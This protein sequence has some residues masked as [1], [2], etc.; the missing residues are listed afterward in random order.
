MR[1]IAFAIS[2]AEPEQ[3][4]LAFAKIK[5]LRTHIEGLKTACAAQGVELGIDTGN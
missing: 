4:T 5:D 2:S 1:D 3:R